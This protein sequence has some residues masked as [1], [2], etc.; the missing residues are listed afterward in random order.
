LLPET[1][2]Q[3]GEPRHKTATPRAIRGLLISIEDSPSRRNPGGAKEENLPHAVAVAAKW[4]S[5][6]KSRGSIRAVVGGLRRIRKLAGFQN[7]PCRTPQPAPSRP[8]RVFFPLGPRRRARRPSLL[9][10]VS[11]TVARRG[12]LERRSCLVAQRLPTH[13]VLV[14]ARLDGN[15]L[16]G[17]VGDDPSPSCCE[18]PPSLNQTTS[19]LAAAVA[20]DPAL[21]ASVA[22]AI[23]GAA[24]CPF[25]GNSNRS[26]GAC[27]G[28]RRQDRGTASGHIRL[29]RSARPRC[30][31]GGGVTGR[32]TPRTQRFTKTSY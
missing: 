14:R 21:H 12:I 13:D 9:E 11:R 5:T 17:R 28:A 22:L 10:R 31:C 4:D 1:W 19:R 8:K 16:G 30:V 3:A 7:R 6:R 23:Y 20:A 18:N 2:W 29:P 27:G 24:A 15:G 32:F 25:S 26:V